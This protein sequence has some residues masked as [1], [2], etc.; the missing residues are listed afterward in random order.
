[1]SLS[2]FEAYLHNN[3]LL[4]EELTRT[5]ELHDKQ[6]ADA[7]FLARTNDD[8]RRRAFTRAAELGVAMSET[9]RDHIAEV[10]RTP[11]R[12]LLRLVALL[13][14]HNVPEGLVIGLSASEYGCSARLSDP[15]VLCRF[16][17][18]K[19]VAGIGIEVDAGDD[20]TLHAWSSTTDAIVESVE[21]VV[22]QDADVAGAA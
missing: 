20:I 11:F 14:D 1:M 15:S 8:V 3:T 18:P 5:A 12:R 10:K 9:Y 2:K 21:Q 13:H 19:V 7:A 22:T 17:T 6:A 16:G 4:V